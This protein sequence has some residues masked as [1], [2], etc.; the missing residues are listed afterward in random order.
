MR[1]Q[2]ERAHET[3]YGHRLM[4]E[5]SSFESGGAQRI[6]IPPAVSCIVTATRFSGFFPAAHGEPSSRSRITAR[7]LS[8]KDLQ[9]YQHV[10]GPRTLLA[11]GTT[12]RLDKDWIAM[13]DEAG[14][15]LLMH[16]H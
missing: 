4:Q 15:L 14:H 1:A 13:R 7:H 12:I 8:V 6:D 9:P 11:P 16:K 2:F 3:R 5:L 10:E